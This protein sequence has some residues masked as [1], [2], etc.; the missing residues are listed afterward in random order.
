MKNLLDII[1][2]SVKT[3]DNK[4][5]KEDVIELCELISGDLSDRNKAAKIERTIY[6]A[7][8]DLTPDDIRNIRGWEKKS[9]AE[10]EDYILFIT[11]IWDELG[12]IADDCDGEDAETVQQYIDKLDEPVN[13]KNFISAYYR[14]LNSTQD[15]SVAQKYVDD[16]LNHLDDIC[17]VLFGKPWK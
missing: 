7:F 11:C 4:T 1:N 2:E 9:D 12:G 3:L 15:K 17:K 10:L 6:K 8:T 13:L 16:V 5:F 14:G